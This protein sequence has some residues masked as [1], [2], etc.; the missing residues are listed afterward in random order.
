[1]TLSP[2]TWHQRIPRELRANLALRRRVN[3]LCLESGAYRRAALEMCRTDILAWVNLFAWQFNPNAI[4][5]GSLESGPFITWPFQDEAILGADR[6]DG[7]HAH[8]ILECIEQRKD[9]VIE[10]SREMGASWLCLLV[11][12]WLFL[13]H[14]W[15][16]FLMISRSEAAV[17]RPGDPDCLFWKLD[18]VHRHLPEWM[19]GPRVRRRKL[20]FDNPLNGST[21]TG[22]ASTGK[23]GVGGR[24]TCMFVDEFSQIDEDFE[25]LHRTSDTTS[26]RIFN[27][28]H[29]GTH[30]CFY[31]LC[32]PRSEEGRG[33]RKL[34]MHWSQH[35]DKVRGLYRAELRDGKPHVL[36]KTHHY[37]P[38]F[39]F[40]LDGTPAGGPFPGLRSEWYDEQFP[41]KGRNPRA[42]AM[43]LDINPQ[44]T[45][46]Q[47][48]NEA[49]LREVEAD[50]VRAPYWEGDV[51]YDR[52]SGRF[53]ELVPCP[54]GPLRLWAHPG[55]DGKL[56][57]CGYGVGTDVSTG[58]GA[59]PSCFSAVNDLG[60]KVAEYVTA[61]M[62]PDRFAVLCVALC[63]W[64]GDS[65]LC[66]ET[67]G[68]GATFGRVVIELGYR[69]VYYRV[70]E[71]NP[72]KKF[73]VSDKPGW[74]PSP[75]SKRLELENY[76]AA[77]YARKLVNRSKEALDEC[78]Y[79]MYTPR[80]DVVHS[81][82][83]NPSDPTGSTVNHGDRTIADAL[84]WKMVRDRARLGRVQR[85]GAVPPNSVGGRRRE[86]EEAERLEGSWS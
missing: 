19:A 40:V 9:L 27:G 56:P 72:L 75:Q 76:R 85:E 79:F 66:W 68:P 7:T 23:A 4:G 54:G 6:A 47:F 60:E 15:K 35:P 46:S 81:G 74:Y 70:D 38:G 53:K 65:R 34:L 48:F 14:P 86:R 29:T 69:D 49:L 64:L 51:S 71:E 55:P 44:G 5:G 32:D 50:T 84:A 13:F 61:H 59:T 77:L 45:V 18:H 36:D 83:S 20:G 8:G 26:C 16:K 21:I 58:Q 10:K 82:E 28:T 42:M 24:A 52:E 2:G 11:M 17:D 33:Q 41:R 12:D 62:L 63:R 67:A 22:Q 37:A 78:R 31:K 1:M 73:Q 80:G 39:Q 30:T 57:A 3:R 25:V 43:D